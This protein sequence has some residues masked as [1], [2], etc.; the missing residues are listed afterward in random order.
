MLVIFMLLNT[1]VLRVS[2]DP[3]RKQA[4]KQ[5][6]FQTVCAYYIFN[7]IIIY[8][9]FCVVFYLKLSQDLLSLIGGLYIFLLI[10][11]S[12]I[13][14][15][16]IENSVLC[17]S[18]ELLYTPAGITVYY[19]AKEYVICI[20]WCTSNNFGPCLKVFRNVHLKPVNTKWI[21]GS[22]ILNLYSFPN[23]HLCIISRVWKWPSNSVIA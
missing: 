20:W 8:K 23:E 16:I 15:L 10:W 7:K 3:K 12:Q 5:S 13:V 1:W 4:Y 18:S 17:C 19:F 2:V 6:T 11:I 9:C 14:S 21:H 22:L